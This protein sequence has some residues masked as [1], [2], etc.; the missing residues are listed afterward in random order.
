MK[1]LVPMLLDF[2]GGELKSL[3]LADFKNESASLRGTVPIASVCATTTGKAKKCGTVTPY[4]LLRYDLLNR[5][6]MAGSA[7]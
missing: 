5:G 7:R 4:T 2:D 1:A 6:L 3:M